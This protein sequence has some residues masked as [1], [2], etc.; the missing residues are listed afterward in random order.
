MK[1]EGYL[2]AARTEGRQFE[3]SQT[4]LPARPSSLYCNCTICTRKPNKKNL[5]KVVPGDEMNQGEMG[6]CEL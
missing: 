5:C 2:H 3:H 6:R 4:P 1:K